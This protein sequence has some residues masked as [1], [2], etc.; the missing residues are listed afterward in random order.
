MFLKYTQDISSLVILLLPII[1]TVL[2]I[3]FYIQ[4]LT[5]KVVVS[6]TVS[7]QFFSAKYI[8][9]LLITNKR[10]NTL[11]I[12]SVYA[13]IHKDIKIELDKFSTPLILKPYET[14]A[15]SLPK[16][17]AVTVGSDE[18]EPDY[19]FDSTKIY[20][21]IG[22][23]LLLC[24][25]EEKKNL[26]NAYRQASTHTFRFGEHIYNQDVAFILAYYF[27]GRT[28]TAFI[29]EKGFIG[30]EWDFTPNHFG[31]RQVSKEAIEELLM[32][33][34]Y[35]KLFSNFLCYKVNFPNIQLLFRKSSNGGISYE[36]SK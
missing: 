8:S 34:G 7:M 32:K 25:A 24:H 1:G 18:Y 21:D 17:S 20:I 5:K 29:D 27:E 15:I 19:S 22:S 31:S 30:N 4:K 10:D 35:D 12:W 13:T 2:G 23:E 14:I 16:F 9:N 6:Y 36:E 26:L 3:Y 11:S 33:N 28:Y